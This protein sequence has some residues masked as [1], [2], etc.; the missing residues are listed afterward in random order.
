MRCSQMIPLFLFAALFTVSGCDVLSPFD[1]TVE[2][3][4][5]VWVETMPTQCLSNPWQ[6]EW[7]KR[8]G[9]NY[10]AYP[11][12][13]EQEIVRDFFVKRG[14][15]FYDY[16][17]AWVAEAVCLACSCPEGYVLFLRV[18]KN[19]L[20]V[21]E[22][23]DFRI[24]GANLQLQIDKTV[25][26]SEETVTFKLINSSSYA[27]A[28]NGVD[29]FG[30]EGLLVVKGSDFIVQREQEGFWEHLPLP[31][32]FEGVGRFIIDPN[33]TRQG[34]WLN[35]EKRTGKFQLLL[36][37]QIG[38]DSLRV[39][40]VASE[41][42]SITS[43][44]IPFDAGSHNLDFGDGYVLHADSTHL[45]GDFLSTTVSYSGGCRFHEFEVRLQ[46]IDNLTAYIFI[47]HHANSDPCEAYP[48]VAL[49]SN[50]RAL[51]QRDDW[52]KLVLLA[53]GGIE[54]TLRG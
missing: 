12:A 35:Y 43:N 42:F 48:T 26:D 18:H 50:L 5:L 51:L 14:A 4:N 1:D 30:G 29:G 45:D 11:R 21:F 53:P 39:G 28:A 49:R 16:R 9:N 13:R 24:S 33:E 38:G 3:K 54:I 46:R 37:V 47:H 36:R 15:N 6:Q 27:F 32:A 52:D 31:P 8:H 34:Y 10:N 17:I 22:Q 25:F 7:L 19:H 2:E 20:P 44:L 23:F 40:Y 41:S